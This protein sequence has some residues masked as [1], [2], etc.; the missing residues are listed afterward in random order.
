ME[1]FLFGALQVD[2]ANLESLT[3]HSTVLY[4]PP[5]INTPGADR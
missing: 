3:G 2:Q 5:M 1:F 4:T